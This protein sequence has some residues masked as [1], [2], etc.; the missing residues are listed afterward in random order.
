MGASMA[1]IQT[2]IYYSLDTGTYLF[3]NKIWVYKKKLESN[4]I[5]YINKVKYALVI[6]YSKRTL[7]DKVNFVK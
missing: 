7:S 5:S 4:L 2:R 6:P 3:Y 1:D